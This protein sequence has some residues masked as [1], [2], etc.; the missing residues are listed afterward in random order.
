V[1][2]LEFG[3]NLLP[4]RGTRACLDLIELAERVGWDFVGLGDSQLLWDDVCV[5]LA[6]AAVSTRRIRLGAWV[7]NTVTRHESVTVNAVRTLDE[8]SGGRAMLGAG[9][10]DSSVK[11]LGLRPARLAELVA[12]VARMRT[13]A[14]GAEA[15]CGSGPFR[16]DGAAGPLPIYWAADGPKSL[17]DAGRYADAVIGNGLLVPAHLDF[18]R[19]H[20]A[21]GAA[22]AGRETAPGLVFQTGIV[23]DDDPAR[24]RETAK[25]YLVRT[26]AH[27]VSAWLPGWSSGRSKD[28]RERY[29][30][31]SH[32]KQ[33]HR[34]SAEVP[35]E[36]VGYKAV[37]GTPEECA[38]RLGELVDT[39]VRSF[40]LVPLGDRATAIRRFAEEVRPLIETP[41]RLTGTH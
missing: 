35:D 15:D 34:L 24:A 17:F 6:A 40:S 20:I 39:G 2:V 19:G 10:G 13:L 11:M 38:K 7:S 16:L 22:A 3:V 23:I 5:L 26:L 28:F 21:A 29:E 33:G 31:Y 37:A 41:G 25:P 30:Y 1:P 32:I 12:S 9:Y 4:G 36:L 14:S 8:L 18:M 27:E